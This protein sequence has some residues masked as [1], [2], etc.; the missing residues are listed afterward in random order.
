MSDHYSD[1]RSIGRVEV[2][3]ISIL[4]FEV[5]VHLLGLGAFLIE[6]GEIGDGFL[7]GG[8]IAEMLPLRRRRAMRPNRNPG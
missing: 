8:A 2:I 6:P 7:R 3:S 1:T 5:A 4:S